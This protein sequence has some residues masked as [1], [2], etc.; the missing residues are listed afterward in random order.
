VKTFKIWDEVNARNA[1]RK[2]RR[3]RLVI[4]IRGLVQGIAGLAK[5][6]R[7]SADAD[8]LFLLT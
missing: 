7:Q 5:P 3:R 1:W 8:D 6:F 4:H 2:E